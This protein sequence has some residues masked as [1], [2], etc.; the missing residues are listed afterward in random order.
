MLVGLEIPILG[1]VTVPIQYGNGLTKYIRCL[2]SK[3]CFDYD[4]I[5]GTSALRDLGFFLGNHHSEIGL[6]FSESAAQS[7]QRSP[8][9]NIVRVSNTN[10]YTPDYSHRAW[11]PSRSSGGKGR[12]R[13]T[14]NHPR[15][16]KSSSP[17]CPHP[18]PDKKWV[19][20]SASFGIVPRPR[21]HLLDQPI[22]SPMGP[23]KYTTP[24]GSHPRGAPIRSMLHDWDIPQ[25]QSTTADFY[26]HR[27]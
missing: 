10:T 7:F 4:L 9:L 18:T 23:L 1:L 8:K 2:I 25:K 21:L 13:K 27:C 19:P 6:E 3:E 11:G 5:L 12:T 20:S 17:R 15:K 16:R 26:S 22:C 14:Q 24:N